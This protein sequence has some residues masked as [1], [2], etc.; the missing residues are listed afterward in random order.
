MNDYRTSKE[1][2]THQELVALKT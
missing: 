2:Y 1:E